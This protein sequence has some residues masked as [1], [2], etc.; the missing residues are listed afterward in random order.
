M[1]E[2]RRREGSRSTTRR[3]TGLSSSREEEEATTRSSASASPVWA[4]S[5]GSRLPTAVN[6]PR[7]EVSSK[8]QRDGKVSA[9]KA[10]S[11][12][13]TRREKKGA[14]EEKDPRFEA[15]RRR[16]KGRN[17]STGWRWWEGSMTGRRRVGS[18]CWEG[19]CSNRLGRL[20]QMGGSYVRPEGVE[21][22]DSRRKEA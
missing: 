4:S 9:P 19:S 18:R 14:D 16:R 6:V 8:N 5:F 13:S 21:V 17:C 20:K 11:C 7:P 2:G 3:R 15:T 1:V 22:R 10:E 12:R